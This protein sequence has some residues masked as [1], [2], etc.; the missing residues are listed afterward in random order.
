ME[1]C[2]LITTYNRKE[3]CQRLVDSLKDIGDIIV[4]GDS[5]DYTITGCKFI[6]LKW[7]N[8]RVNYWLTVKQLFSLR[9]HHK[10][11]I[12][13]PDDFLTT[14]EMIKKALETWDAIEDPKKI[15]LNLFADRI[16]CKCWTNYMPRDRGA[17]WQTGWVDM[18]FLAEEKFFTSVKIRNASV[19]PRQ[20]S[21]VGQ[22]ISSQLF[23]QGYHLYQVKDSLVTT[24]EAHGNSEMHKQ[25]KNEDYRRN[26]HH[27]LK[28]RHP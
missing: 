25:V 18:C 2:F 21:G 13:I 8:G 16:N 17:V 7:H 28:R 1:T 6:N 12:M 20:S 15:C 11:Y 19:F 14:P 23:R 3:S 5:V 27:P 9:G 26:S 22:Q 10:Y 4:L 24:Q